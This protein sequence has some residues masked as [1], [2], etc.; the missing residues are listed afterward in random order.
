MDAIKKQATKLREQ[1]A[2]QQQAILKHLRHFG[3]EDVI[4]DEAEFRCYQQLQNL[5]SSTRA[6]KHYQRNIVR[7]IG[8]FVSTTSKQMEIARKLAEDCC[9][10]GD[11]N[12]SVNTHVARAT[13]QF[14]TSHNLMENES[15][16]FLGV[17]GDQVSEP[18]RALITGAPLE[19]A[20]HLTNR[21]DKLRQEVEAQAAEVL[22]LR[23]KTR[24]SDINAENCTRL[25]GSETRLNDL[26]ST[27]MALGREATAAMLAVEDQQQQI[28]AQRLFTM[29]DAE[30]CYHQH[31]LSILDK[32]YDEMILEEQLNESSSQSGTTEKAMNVLAAPEDSTPNDQVTSNGKYDVFFAKVIHPFDAQGEGELSLSVDDYVVVSQVAPTGWSKGECKG[33]TGWFPSAYIDKLEKA[34]TSEEKLVKASTSEGKLE[35]A[36]I[37]EEKQEEMPANEMI[38]A[39]SKS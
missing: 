10:Y 12:Q 8:S 23:S 27:M 26:K 32:L 24:D 39:T 19:D 33:H 14:G 11:D 4:I 2:K 38:E 18:L 21:Y 13:L 20:R 34:P 36:P 31:V 29:V 1:V 35:K 17:L 28:T 6:A 22:R 16:T 7:C 15:E 3:H 37:I 25:R 5:Y 30:R 9:K